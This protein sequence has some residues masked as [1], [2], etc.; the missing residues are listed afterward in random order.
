[1]ETDTGPCSDNEEDARLPSQNAPSEEEES[2]A[3][4]SLYD[5]EVPVDDTFPR[6]GS[7][8][9]LNVESLMGSQANA[10]D[11]GLGAALVSYS[12]LA[13]VFSKQRANILPPHRPYNCSIDLYPGT[14]PPRGSLYSLSAPESKAMREYIR[15]VLASGFIR[16][17]TSPAGAGFFFVSKKDG[18]LR[19]CIDYQGLNNITVKNRYPLPLM[20]CAFERLQG[21]MFFTKLDLRDAYNLVRIHEGDEWKTGFNTH[22]GHEYLVMPFGLANTLS[23]FQAFVN[24]VL[25]EMLERFVFVYL[26]DIL[27]FS[28]NLSD[29]RRHIRQVLK[30]LLDGKLFVKAETQRQFHFSVLL[31][32]K[33]QCI[34]TWQKSQ[35][36]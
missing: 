2:L 17:S 25:G 4:D 35:P 9:D 15:E 21:A 34:S 31:F 18:G 7:D 11:W 20:N 10:D 32:P 26:D 3:W 36:S 5:W 22:D 12:D 23:V 1:M 6:E 19:P 28:S 33:G 8:S 24:D 27:I 13:E 16:P 29:H 14:I 30:A